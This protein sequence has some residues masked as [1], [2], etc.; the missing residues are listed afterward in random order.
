MIKHFFQITA[1]TGFIAICMFLPYIPGDYDGFAVTLSIMAQLSGIASVLLVPPGII[2]LIS[3][4]KS[5]RQ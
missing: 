2:W 3:E 1:I 5:R 4:I